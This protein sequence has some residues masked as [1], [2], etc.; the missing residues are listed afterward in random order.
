MK[1]RNYTK[2]LAGLVVVLLGMFAALLF[3]LPAGAGD[4]VCGHVTLEWIRG[5]VPAAFEGKM[6]LDMIVF[7]ALGDKSRELAAMPSAMT[8]ITWTIWGWRRRSR[9]RPVKRRTA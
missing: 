7:P 2:S 6:G 1:I 9:P 5:Q 8:M 4:D 3:A